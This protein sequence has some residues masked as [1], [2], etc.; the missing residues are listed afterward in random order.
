MLAGGEEATVLLG[1]D[2][3][4]DAELAG[5]MEAISGVRAAR[6]RN[7]ETRLALVG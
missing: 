6:L 1:R 4:L 7:S 3:L 5:Q 2:F